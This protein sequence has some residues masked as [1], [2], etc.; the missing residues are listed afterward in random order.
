MADHSVARE[1][2]GPWS[3]AVSRRFW[4]GFAPNELDPRQHE[5]ELQT[6]FLSEADWTPISARVTQDAATARIRVS[7][8]GDLDAA[9]DQVARFLSLD[10]DAAEW[11]V[12]GERDPVIGRCQEA[13]P[14]LRPC[15]FFS[16]YEAAAWA[17]LSQRVRITQAASLRARIVEQHG[18]DGAFP[19]PSVLRDLRLGLPGRKDDYLAAVADAALDGILSTVRL[20]TM[21]PDDAMRDVQG[22]AGIGPFAAELIVLRGANAPDAL[23]THEDRLRA[24]LEVQYG[25]DAD[26]VRISEAWRPLRTWAIVALRAMREERTGEIRRGRRDR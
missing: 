2:I 14:G 7:G 24:E 20:R 16:A 6:A 25:A 4:E 17:V 13:M 1:V 21:D 9:A 5:G 26:L 15:G 22:I 23:P 18:A 11:P 8:A 3:L 12:I 19:A 10:V